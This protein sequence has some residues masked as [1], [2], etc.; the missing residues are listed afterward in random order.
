MAS[1]QTWP[2]LCLPLGLQV[3]LQICVGESPRGITLPTEGHRRSFSIRPLCVLVTQSCSTLSKPTR[4]CPWNSL[5]KNTRVGC[6]SHLQGIFLT[7]RSN[8]SLL[9]C[10]QSHYRLNHQGRPIQT[11]TGQI[12][13]ISYLGIEP[14]KETHNTHSWKW[15]PIL[16]I[17]SPEG[18]GQRR[19]VQ[20]VGN[21][22]P[23]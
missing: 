21:R 22:L 13:Q 9:H 11:L 8:L 16:I 18:L 10:R 7:Q 14:W 20:R 3:S 15:S 19:D 4:L 23:W 2:L 6:H 5:G 1:L 17:T 12:A